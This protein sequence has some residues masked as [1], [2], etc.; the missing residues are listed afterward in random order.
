MG[1][2]V[3]STAVRLRSWNVGRDACVRSS[4]GVLVTSPNTEVVPSAV[5]PSEGTPGGIR[6][7]GLVGHLSGTWAMPCTFAPG[8]L[9]GGS[10]QLSARRY[11]RSDSPSRMPSLSV[12]LMQRGVWLRKA[13]LPV[14][15]VMLTRKLMSHWGQGSVPVRKP[16][17]PWSR[18]P[19]GTPGKGERKRKIAARSPMWNVVSR[20]LD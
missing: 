1:L 19:G 20:A 17:P 11:S 15:R 5:P 9:G 8:L 18:W 12:G 3:P 13:V 7:E 16:C 14:D 4:R 6:F 10:G 2:L